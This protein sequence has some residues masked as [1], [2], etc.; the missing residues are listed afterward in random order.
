[1]PRLSLNVQASERSQPDGG[2]ALPL[3]RRRTDAAAW[4]DARVWQPGPAIMMPNRV[5]RRRW[6]G[7]AALLAGSP[8]GRAEDAPN[9]CLQPLR[10]RTP[11][12]RPAGYWPA[13]HVADGELAP[14]GLANTIKIVPGLPGPVLYSQQLH[15][16][17]PINAWRVADG[18]TVE[19]FT[20]R[21]PSVSFLDKF[22]FEPE[23][24]R[25]LGASFQGVF[26]YDVPS[27][28]FRLVA[29]AY[30]GNHQP[31]PGTNPGFRGD[32]TVLPIP[33]LGT[34]LVGTATGLFQLRGNHVERLPDAGQHASGRVSVH[35]DLPV[36][37]GMMI[38][39][40]GPPK[41]RHD[42][43]TVE[44]LVEAYAGYEFETAFES[45]RPGRILLKN[46][47]KLVEVEMLPGASGWTPGRSRVLMNSS[48]NL[49]IDAVLT[50]RG[51][52]LLL[53]RPAWLLW[54]HGLERLEVDG[55]RPVPGDPVTIVR[56]SGSMHNLP[57][58]ATG[59]A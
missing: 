39:T 29:D 59:F 54:H 27:R 12:G 38:S 22:A 3:H 45:L 46:L 4:N 47:K 32:I 7:I 24:R 42:D 56:E 50:G 34:T 21:F 2:W 55:L 41:F 6:P 20:G 28:Q 31:A 48:S 58:R 36:H 1:M 16:P 14:A 9:L 52:Y 19:A 51:E 11:D 25:V 8:P 37:Q 13:E 23:G 5:G 57:S 17:N 40:G 26:A 53:G 18:N 43:G 10:V 33:R 49:S 30:W 15:E 44:T 35:Q